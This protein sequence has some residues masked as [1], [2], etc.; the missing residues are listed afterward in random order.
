MISY[1]LNLLTF[2]DVC[3]LQENEVL[4]LKCQIGTVGIFTSTLR[5]LNRYVQQRELDKYSPL[6]WC[7]CVCVC[8]C[9]I[10]RSLYCHILDDSSGDFGYVS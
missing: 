9:L 7:L 3:S 10:K 6:C 1:S 4:T 2:Y 5:D 8:V